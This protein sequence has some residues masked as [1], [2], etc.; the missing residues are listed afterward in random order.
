MTTQD[1]TTNSLPVVVVDDEP[2]IDSRIIAGELG[3]EHLSTMKNVDNYSD[4]FQSF[5]LIRFETEAVRVDGGRGTKYAKFALLNENQAYFLV[6]LSRN[7]EQAVKLKQRLVQAFSDC[8][9]QAQ[10][11]FKVPQTFGEAL[12]L[13]ADLHEQLE[14]KTRQVAEAQPMVQFHEE[15]SQADSE[16]NVDETCAA[17]FNGA[18]GPKQLRAWLKLNHW[19]DGRP[20]MNK[21]TAWAMH[22]GL[23][24]L[25]LSPPIN[26]RIFEV[27]ILTGKGIST[28]RHLYR[29]N[30][31][32]INA[33]PLE[34]R[35]PAPDLPV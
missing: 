24:R 6:T 21:P 28:L 31:L 32:F 29:T 12:R 4:S 13:A 10:Q 26:G 23:M 11:Q 14:E 22:Q 27:P 3:V 34:L 17:L 19:L 15:V 18:I 1:Y 20:G 16:L 5:G 25:R 33:V 9:Q 30:E 8:R 2:R 7:S 35:L